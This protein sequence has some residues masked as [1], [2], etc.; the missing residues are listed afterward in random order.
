MLHRLNFLTAVVMLI[1]AGTLVYVVTSRDGLPAAGEQARAPEKRPRDSGAAQER[2][3]VSVRTRPKGFADH[4]GGALAS[5][6][7]E[8]RTP[9]P[10]RLR[11]DLRVR[12]DVPGLS[13]GDLEERAQ[14]VESFALRR[15]GMLTEQLDL[16][17]AQQA[18]IFPILARGSQSYD[19]RMN[20]VSGSQARA[21]GPEDA[22]ALDKSRQQALLEDELSAAQS[23]ELVDQSI[24]DLL[25]WEEIIDG[26][27]NQLDQATP[28]QIDEVP[29][30]GTTGTPAPVEDIAVP[31]AEPVAPA[32][33]HGGRNLF[34]QLVPGN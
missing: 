8:L 16:T 12:V 11:S 3:T 5:A 33:S 4:N 17:A 22:A 29:S 9:R 13:N 34:D 24:K 23:D 28:G 20:I 27:A 31:A 15:L 25:I 1:V 14:R 21:L 7:A 18:R 10:G 26:L 32:E 6:A 30:D 2:S 19:P